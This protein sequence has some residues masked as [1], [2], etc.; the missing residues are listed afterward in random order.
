L[1]FEF[2]RSLL[3]SQL[4]TL[5]EEI[6]AEDDFKTYVAGTATVLTAAVSAGYVFWG[7]RGSF[8]AASFLSTLPAWRHID[9]LPVVDQ[10][11]GPEEEDGESLEDIASSKKDESNAESER[12]DAGSPKS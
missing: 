3:W 1:A 7:L 12:R 6:E 10:F 9:P 5:R 11:E 2:Q 8:L 4:D